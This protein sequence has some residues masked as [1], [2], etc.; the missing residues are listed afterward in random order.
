MLHIIQE[1]DKGMS[2]ANA[3]KKAARG[4]C[5]IAGGRIVGRTKLQKI[6]YLLS[7]AGLEDGLPFVY[8]H[9]W[10]IQRGSGRGCP[11]SKSAGPP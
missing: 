7:I 11:Y 10:A 6:A 3:V 1:G 5:E 4:W 9:L 8:K 2:Y